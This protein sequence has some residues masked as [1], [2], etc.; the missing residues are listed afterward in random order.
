MIRRFITWFFKDVRADLRL[1]NSNLKARLFSMRCK[2][3][4][5]RVKSVYCPE[6]GKPMARQ[7]FSTTK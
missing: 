1:E 2:E 7:I 3:H 5:G 6:C 4:T